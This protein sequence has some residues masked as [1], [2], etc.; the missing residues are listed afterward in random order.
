MK[1]TQQTNLFRVIAII[2]LFLF[3][4]LGFYRNAITTEIGVFC[5]KI[6]NSTAFLN[7]HQNKSLSFVIL[8]SWLDT[9]I[10]ILIYLVLAIGVIYFW[11]QNMRYAYLSLAFILVLLLASFIVLIIYKVANHALFYRFSEDLIYFTLSPTPLLLL[12]VFFYLTEYAKKQ[13]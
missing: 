1:M 7:S 6:F 13:H 10:Y 4:L 2:L 9:V 8:F 5:S 12:V 11:F 3:L